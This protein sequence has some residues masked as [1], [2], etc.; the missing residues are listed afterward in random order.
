MSGDGVIDIVDFA[1]IKSQMLG[2]L[3]MTGIQAEAAVST[4]HRHGR[5]SWISPNMKS[6]MLGA[7][8]IPQH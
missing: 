4:G 8:Q 7:L 6:Y 2:Q 5:I 3:T 1:Y